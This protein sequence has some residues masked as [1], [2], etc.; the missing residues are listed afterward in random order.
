[1]VRR[2]ATSVV[3]PTSID[4]GDAYSSVAIM[5]TMAG[6]READSWLAD[7]RGRIETQY[8]GTNR[9]ATGDVEATV[10]ELR[11]ALTNGEVR[12]AEPTDGDWQVNIW[13][14]K[15]VLMAFRAGH[16]KNFVADPLQ[17]F[18]DLHTLPPRRLVEKDAVRLVPGG[19]A[20]REGAHIARGVVCMP[21][22]FVNVG[23]YVDEDTMIDSHAL[24]GSCA[25]VGK[26]VHIS[27]GAQIGGILEPVGALPVIVED[28]VLVG[29]NCGVFA[30][31]RV[32]RGAVLAAGTILTSS[33]KIYDLVDQRILTTAE[34]GY[35]AVPPRSVIVPGSRP[36]SGEFA[37]REGL[38][39]YAPLLVSYRDAATDAAATLENALRS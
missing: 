32:G 15:G 24:V 25:Q 20:I 27:A 6:N 11:D 13:V 26:R 35:L 30:G 18:F 28:D 7:L 39:V 34:G 33:T 12:A 21:P 29:G 38:H 17:S 3:T 14:K 19:S 36:A 4:F 23:A 1:M 31:V 10:A 16:V 9:H 8:D 5:R 37:Q 22:M 2:S